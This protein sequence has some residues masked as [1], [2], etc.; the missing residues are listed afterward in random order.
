MDTKK[1][2]LD[3]E[4]STGMI[5]N[6]GLYVGTLTNDPVYA[7]EDGVGIETLTSLKKA[8]YTADDIV[9]LKQRDI[10]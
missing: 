6:D 8:G 2:V 3:W 7:S 1:I 5:Y 9:L 10:I 4:G